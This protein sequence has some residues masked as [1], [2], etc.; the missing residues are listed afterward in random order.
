MFVFTLIESV[1]G[2]AINSIAVI[3]DALYDLGDSFS[4]GP[5]WYFANISQRS[6]SDTFSYGYKRFSLL[7]ALICG[8]I[9]LMDSLLIVSEIVQRIVMPEQSH[10][11]GM[12]LF[13]IIGVAVNGFAIT[14]LKGGKS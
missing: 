5:A 3:A 8:L 7:S 14:R 9:L 11:P 12:V 13:A 2:Y 4:L 10:A 6:I 1:E